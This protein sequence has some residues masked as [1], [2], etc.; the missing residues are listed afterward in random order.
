MTATDYRP[1]RLHT[2]C[3][4]LACMGDREM[5]A[6]SELHHE[7]RN[8]DIPEAHG[9]I[10]LFGRWVAKSGYPSVRTGVSRDRWVRRSDMRRAIAALHG[11]VI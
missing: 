6:L 9:D 2:A 8:R 5:I 11:I 10:R 4:I 1:E 7:V 3:I